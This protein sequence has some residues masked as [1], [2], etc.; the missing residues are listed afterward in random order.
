MLIINDSRAQ[1]YLPWPV[2]KEFLCVQFEPEAVAISLQFLSVDVVLPAL[3]K[4]GLDT[5]HVSVQLALNLPRPYD[6]SSQRRK[7][8]D[9]AYLRCTAVRILHL[10]SK[11]TTDRH[12]DVGWL[13]STLNETA[14]L[15]QSLFP[16]RWLMWIQAT[17]SVSTHQIFTTVT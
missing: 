5:T 6:R 7:V 9:T 3:T 8:S 17:N 11:Y 10:Q 2:L 13:L 4:H 12:T 16:T 15:F 14:H 1:N